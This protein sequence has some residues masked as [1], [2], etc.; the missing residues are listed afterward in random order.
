MPFNE[1][2]S[3]NTLQY[4][5]LK[6]PYNMETLCVGDIVYIKP[7]YITEQSE[8]EWVND[9]KILGFEYDYQISEMSNC[10]RYRVLVQFENSTKVESFLPHV[11]NIRTPNMDIRNGAES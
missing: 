6:K 7:F 3:E 8:V 9:A 2:F 11:F 5:N 10:D 1:I 4:E